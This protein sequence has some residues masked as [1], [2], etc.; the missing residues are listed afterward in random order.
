MSL[1]A[2]SPIFNVINIV[3]IS[4]VIKNDVIISI[5]IVSMKLTTE[6]TKQRAN[7]IKLFTAVIYGFLQ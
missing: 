2:M 4:K 1:L 7:P 5:V 3:I 6:I